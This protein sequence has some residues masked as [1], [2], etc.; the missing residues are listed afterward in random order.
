MFPKGKLIEV[1]CNSNIQQRKYYVRKTLSNKNYIFNCF[2][3]IIQVYCCER[4]SNV[5]IKHLVI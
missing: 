3:V 1:L 4:F 2:N 5:R